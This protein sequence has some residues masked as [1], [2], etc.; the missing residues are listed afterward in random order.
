MPDSILIVDDNDDDV[1]A[2]KRALRHAGIA[3]PQHVASHGA[4]ALDYLAGVGRYGDRERFPLP[5]V[6]FLDLKMP[7]LDG[8]EVLRWIRAQ[9]AFSDIAV[10]ILTGS[11]HAQDHQRAAALG[12]Q[13]SWVKPASVTDLR[14]LASVIGRPWHVSGI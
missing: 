2:L 5:R 4:E 13:A 11:D 3:N 12:A 1:Y 14:Q 9:P 8:F 7:F 6:V 10:V